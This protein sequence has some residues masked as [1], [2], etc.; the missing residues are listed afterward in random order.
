MNVFKVAINN[1]ISFKDH[2]Y[3]PFNYLKMIAN[4]IQQFIFINDMSKK[5][6]YY[7]SDQCSILMRNLF[8]IEGAMLLNYHYIIAFS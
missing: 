6:G 7:Y 3:F 1:F 2:I 4:Y 5:E 8:L